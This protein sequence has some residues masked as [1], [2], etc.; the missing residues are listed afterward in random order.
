MASAAIGLELGLAEALFLQGCCGNINGGD[1]TSGEDDPVVRQQVADMRTGDVAKRFTDQI[2]PALKNSETT[3]DVT[4]DARYEHVALPQEP[5]DAAEL[6]R[7]VVENRPV[8]EK[9][10]LEELRP[11]SE[12]YG[13]RETPEERAWR[14]ARYNVDWATH[15]LELIASGPP[16]E[17]A[18]PVQVLRIG[19][20]ALVSW[21]GEI[22]VEPGLEVRQQSPVPLTFVVTF[23]NGN[24]GYI[25]TRA[26]YESQGR[27]HEFGAYPTTMTPR[28]YG[29]HPFR[30]E[31]AEILVTETLRMLESTT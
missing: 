2:L 27:P 25:P 20:A 29:R 10:T 22:Y 19:P 9:M 28:I 12:R 8:A 31:A 7:I 13:G 14:E 18:A 16:Y 1:L 26:A 21:P 6:E 23:A 15:Q 17:L 11:L 4:L 30:P 5:M 3:S 24:V